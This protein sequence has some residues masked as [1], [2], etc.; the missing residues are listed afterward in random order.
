M[1]VPES[2]PDVNTLLPLVDP[3]TMADSVPELALYANEVIAAE[4]MV[5]DVATVLF[6]ELPAT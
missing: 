5:P 4:S 1:Y 6:T 2:S 3:F